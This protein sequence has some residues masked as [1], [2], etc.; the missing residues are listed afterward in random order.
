V[1]VFN[2]TIFYKDLPVGLITAFGA[3]A[4]T[5]THK[6]QTLQGRTFLMVRP[7]ENAWARP[8]F[9]F[10]EP[11][12]VQAHPKAT[13]VCTAQQIAAMLVQWE[14][15]TPDSLS[16]KGIQRMAI[17]YP[18]PKPYGQN[19][20]RLDLNNDGFT[21]INLD[22]ENIDLNGNNR[23]APLTAGPVGTTNTSIPMRDRNMP[24]FIGFSDVQQAGVA[25]G[26][27]SKSQVAA[28]GKIYVRIFVYH[29]N[30]MICAS[31]EYE[32]VNARTAR[33]VT[34]RYNATVQVHV[35]PA[36]EDKSIIDYLIASLYL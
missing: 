17:A 6:V 10:F 19:A 31:A 25:I 32:A 30:G 34:S 3:N 23:T 2:D 26:T 35:T 22:L 12:Q 29:P 15:L 14:V 27:Y 33:L 18:K 5:I 36:M 1:Y 20:A 11:I 8:V 24:V 13:D 21:D 7:S 16:R 4:S 28:N 9:E